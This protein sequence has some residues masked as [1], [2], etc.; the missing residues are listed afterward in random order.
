MEIAT[1][2][3][4]DLQMIHGRVDPPDTG[5]FDICTSLSD[6]N[7]WPTIVICTKVLTD[8]PHKALAIDCAIALN[9][10]I[11]DFIKL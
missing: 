11:M 8:P 6:K 10:E 3:V 4:I 1:I 7:I 5:Y 9:F 2:K